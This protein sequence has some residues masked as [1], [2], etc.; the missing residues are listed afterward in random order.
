MKVN[1][2][3]VSNAR[4]LINAG[5][6]DLTGAWSFSA[7]DGNKLLGENGDDWANFAKWHLAE[8]ESADEET[9]ARYKY[10]FGKNG[11]VYRRGVIAAK[12]RA[13]QQ[14]D[15]AIEEAADA[16]L[17]LIDSKNDVS[18]LCPTCG[19]E[20]KQGECDNCGAPTG[21]KMKKAKADS[22]KKGVQRVDV[23]MTNP[24]W[25]TEP[26]ERT[27]EGFLRGRAIVTSIGV[28]QYADA[29]GG[30]H[31]ELRLPE[32][33]FEDGSLES[34][35]MKPLTNDH[36]T[37][38][39]EPA[40]VRDL[41]VGSLGSNPSSQDQCNAYGYTPSQQMTDGKHVAIDMVIT[42]PQAISD[43][44][45][46]K[47]SLSCGYT[48]DL[49]Q[50]SG[51]YLGM[52][53]DFVQRNIRYNHVAIVDRAR[54]GDAAMI[55]MDSSEMAVR[56]DS[57]HQAN[58]EEDLMKVVKIDGV[59]YQAEAP[60]I[61]SLTLANERVDA[62]TAEVAQLKTDNSTLM[63]ERDTTKARADQLEA[64]SKNK[65]D[66]TAIQTAIRERRAVERVAQDAGIEFKD[67]EADADIK[68]RIIAKAFPKL[69]LDGK[70]EAYVHASYDAAVATFSE[71]GN[72]SQRQ[73]A[74]GTGESHADS[75]EAQK[76]DSSAARERMIAGMTGRK[77]E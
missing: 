34:L 67:D 32:D 36:P 24:D 47:R 60:V 48:C 40:N 33:V 76:A 17:T 38:M 75:G 16:L 12:S 15:T 45:N 42:D 35:K 46:G 39:V 54:A 1:K 26:F 25:M 37:L 2:A 77:G 21:T 8:D 44:I 4:A 64:E 22:V 10:P 70:D 11:K 57:G 55:R 43:V 65:M 50:K 56:I 41:A 6:V 13:A 31:G 58:S 27:T 19:M 14:G 23:Y 74:K 62:L 5:D 20:M 73:A 66:A 3:G 29:A 7:A 53:Y 63:A 52:P 51:T 49:E 9:K 71:E 68:R 18:S 61:A 30:L 59:E 69:S 72:A 28:F